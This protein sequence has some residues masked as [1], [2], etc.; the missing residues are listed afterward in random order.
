MKTLI[1][2]GKVFSKKDGTPYIVL[3]VFD[4]D[5]AQKYDYTTLDA[6][7]NHDESAKECIFVGQNV[8]EYILNEQDIKDGKVEIDGKLCLGSTVRV[9]QEGNPARVTYIKVSKS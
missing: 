9:F 1:K 4:S 7:I 2:I 3:S 6:V 8:E 5:I